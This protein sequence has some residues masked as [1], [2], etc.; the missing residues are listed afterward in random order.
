M[1]ARKQIE[2]R[3]NPISEIEL[4]MYVRFFDGIRIEAACARRSWQAFLLRW[5]WLPAA[6]SQC[7]R[8]TEHPKEHALANG[9]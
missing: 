1:T 6:I 5:T 2:F 4:E 9:A 3:E 7:D 8:I